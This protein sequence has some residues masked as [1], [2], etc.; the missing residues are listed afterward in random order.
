MKHQHPWV[1]RQRC[2]VGNRSA[3]SVPSCH[4]HIAWWE[5]LNLGM[6]MGQQFLDMFAKASNAKAP[7]GFLSQHVW[8]CQDLKAI[9]QVEKAIHCDFYGSD[10]FQY[11]DK[12]CSHNSKEIAKREKWGMGFYAHKMERNKKCSVFWVVFQE[13]GLIIFKFL[14]G[15]GFGFYSLKVHKCF[16]EGHIFPI[17]K[18][19]LN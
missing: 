1:H 15:L 19:F 6:T 10:L 5:H 16:W 3:S 12:N 4:P 2:S 7:I 9:F 14:W 8:W 17:K 13:S 11:A 18:K